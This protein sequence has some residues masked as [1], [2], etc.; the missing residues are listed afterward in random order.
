MYCIIIIPIIITKRE[1]I[2]GGR[3]FHELFDP[4]R[5]TDQSL[6]ELFSRVRLR[7]LHIQHDDEGYRGPLLASRATSYRLGSFT[8]FAI[9][10]IA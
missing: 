9:S 6:R 5:S 4:V 2:T 10:T 7:D 3:E 8:R 1:I